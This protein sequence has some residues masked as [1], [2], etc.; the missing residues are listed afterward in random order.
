VEIPEIQVLSV[1]EAQKAVGLLVIRV[2]LVIPD[3]KARR[4]RPDTK[5]LPEKW[6][7]KAHA[8]LSDLPVTVILDKK[9]RLVKP[10]LK[11]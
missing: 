4:R 8:A 1:S 7:N 2:I 9:V 11:E 5:V 6:A 10:V 3:Q